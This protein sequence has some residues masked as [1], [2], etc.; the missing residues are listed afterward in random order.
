MD[1]FRYLL[2]I[3]ACLGTIG[4]TQQFNCIQGVADGDTKIESDSA[5][6]KNIVPNT[7]VNV[8]QGAASISGDS[9]AS[10]EEGS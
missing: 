9:N 8:T 3:A 10:L 2:I 1:R 5:A 4:C 6:D 7:P